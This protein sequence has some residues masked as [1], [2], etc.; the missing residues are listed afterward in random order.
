MS[1]RRLPRRLARPHDRDQAGR[2]P[3][4][5]V[6]A[7]ARGRASTPTC[8]SSATGRCGAASRRSQASSGSATAATSSASARTSGR[9]TRRATSSR[10]PRRT[11]GRPSRVIEAQA[12]GQARRLDRRRRRRATSSP[13]ASPASSFRRGDVDAVAD[14][15]A[16]ARRRPGASRALRRGRQRGR[17]ASA[18]PSRGSSTTS[19]VLYRELLDAR[20]RRAPGADSRGPLPRALRRRHDADGQRTLRI[21]LVSQ[22]FPPEI[23]ATQTRM[24]A[25]PSTSPSAATT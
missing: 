9:S 19:T 4:A 16:H 2:R 22:Y 24:Q 17:R 25:S 3:A 11:R 7:P 10:S 8:C 14:R 21:V 18:T 5:R 12:A 23:G 6:R 13:T 15:L 1:R 20:R